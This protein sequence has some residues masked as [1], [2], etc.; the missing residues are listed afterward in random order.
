MVLAIQAN[1]CKFV[2]ITPQE[3]KERMRRIK[4]GETLT[5]DLEPSLT[6]DIEPSLTPN[7][8]PSLTPDLE[9]SMPPNLP[10]P[11]LTQ[12]ANI[13]VASSE[14]YVRPSSFTDE[15]VDPAL[16]AL[17]HGKYL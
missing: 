10:T 2:T 3:A 11:N 9:P 13:C 5:P 8:E 12:P 6:P 17:D 7:L 15:M 1:T 4:D 14:P 16:R